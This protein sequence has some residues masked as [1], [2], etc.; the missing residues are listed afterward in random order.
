[1]TKHAPLRFAYEHV[2]TGAPSPLLA[3]RTEEIRALLRKRGE[4]LAPLEAL[5]TPFDPRFAEDAGKIAEKFWNTHL[6][7]VV[8]VGIGG[9]NLGAE[10]VY[11]ALRA[12]VDQKAHK[13]P[14]LLFVDTVSP[15]LLE[16]KLDL[17]LHEVRH[18]DEILINVISKSGA[19]TET[20][21]NF[22]WLYARL[23]PHI[24]RLSSRVVVTSDAGSALFRRA[25]EAGFATLAIPRPVGGRY[26]VFTPVGLF[27]L[28][29][30]GVDVGALTKGARDAIDA[31]LALDNSAARAADAIAR[32]KNAGATMINFF[33]FNPELESLG[34]WCRQLYAESLGKEFDRNGRTVRAGM[35]PIVSIGSTDLHSTAQLY[36][37]GPRDKFTMFTYVPAK[38]SARIP[39]DAPLAGLVSG[40][41]G[42]TP[43]EIMSAIYGG[44]VA[45]YRARRLPFGEVSIGA[46]SPY[47]LGAYM[48][49]QML[50][51]VFLGELWNVDAFDQ[52]AVEEYKRETKRILAI[53]DK[54][55]R[56]Q[57]GQ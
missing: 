18:A 32:A 28:Q 17:L 50:V 54:T 21:A 31:A 15:A 26:S 57:D 24:P 45:A 35:T 46:V 16:R 39:D 22:D 36:F 19:T 11:D 13:G 10:A 9:S 44:T 55:I 14:R 1:M 23:A 37:G 41:G 2:V 6:K 33:Y 48:A 53:N 30:C 42:R 5:R 49:W 25:A 20:A 52:P 56:R 38:M 43:E 40:I 4:Y 51:V 8:V 27:P 7:Y 3:A 47:A 29:L 34:K 12:A